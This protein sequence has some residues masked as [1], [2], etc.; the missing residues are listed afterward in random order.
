M[1]ARP[2]GMAHRLSLR[3]VATPR[4]PPFRMGGSAKDDLQVLCERHRQATLVRRS[5]GVVAGLPTEQG[6][7]RI[8]SATA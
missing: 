8:F 4:A 1:R 3:Q 6:I 7:L 5:P 2:S